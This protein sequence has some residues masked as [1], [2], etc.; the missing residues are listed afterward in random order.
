MK[1]NLPINITEEIW[2]Y[3]S[4]FSAHQVEI[5]GEKF[6]TV[7]HA[8]QWAK[9]EQ[10]EIKKEIKEAKSPMDAWRVANKHKPETRKDFEKEKRMEELFRAKLAQHSDVAEILK[11][12]GERGILKCFDTDYYWGTGADGSGE[13]RMGKLWMKIRSEM[14]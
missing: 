8:Y 11:L 14:I 3:L 5:W 9:F 7:E 12:S 2:N 6:A 13:N 1:E 4:P 10:E